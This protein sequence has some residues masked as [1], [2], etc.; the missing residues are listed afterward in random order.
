MNAPQPTLPDEVAKRPLH[1]FWIVDGSGSMTGRKIATLNQAIREVL[2]DI[3]KITAN[4]P[5]VQVWMRAIKFSNEAEWHV[6]PQAVE[7][8]NFVWSELATQGCTGTAQAIRLL[9]GELDIE[10]MPPR[11]FPPVCILISDGFCTDANEIYDEALA[12][13]EAMPWGRRAVRL[14]IAIG[15]DESEYDEQQLLKFVNHKDVGLLKAHNPSDLIKYIKWASTAATV[16][17]SAGKSKDGGATTGNV[18]LPPPPKV[19]PDP[20]QVF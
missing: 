17:A 4:H 6:G 9:A 8:E 14:A 15:S 20:S 12:A 11:G 10:K 7:L 2:P 5:E 1:F 16:G 13:L 19:T 18:V 3:Q